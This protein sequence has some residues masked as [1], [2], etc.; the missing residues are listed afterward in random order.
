MKIEYYWYKPWR[1]WVI[2]QVDDEGN[3]IGGA[4]YA[5][6]KLARDALIKMMEKP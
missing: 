2:M 5:P 1:V 6:N 4:E 3:Q